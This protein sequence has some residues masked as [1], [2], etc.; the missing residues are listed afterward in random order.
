MVCS[1]LCEKSYLSAL[2]TVQLSFYMFVNKFINYEETYF[3][4]LFSLRRKSYAGDF[5]NIL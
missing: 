3:D 4:Q 1:Y 5:T 2:W